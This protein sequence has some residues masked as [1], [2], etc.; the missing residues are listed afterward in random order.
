MD[1]RDKKVL[2]VGLARTGE[3]TAGFLLRRGARV[4]IT[5]KK[6]REALGPKAETWIRQ[7]VT[8]E[9]GGH[10]LASFL[11]SDLIVPSPGVPRVPEFAA[12]LERGIPV[13]SEI[14]LASRYLKGTIVGI[15]GT[16]GKSTTTTLLHRIL[17]DAGRP[18][19]LAGNIGTPLI[20]FVDR[21]R[22]DHFYVTEISSFQLEYIPTFRAALAL[23]LNIS[24]N[25]LDWHGTLDEYAAAKAKLLLGQRPGDR[26]VLNREDARIWSWKDKA[27]SD[28]FGFS[29]RRPVRRGAFIQDEWIV[30]RND[31]IVRDNKVVMHNKVVYDEKLVR[32][33]RDQRILPVSEIKLPGLHNREN[34]LAAALAARLLGI[35]ASRIRASVRGFRGL[36]HRLEPVLTVRGVSFV[37]DSKATTVDATL[38]ALA[39]F[40][41]PLILILGGKD[42]GADFQP[43]RRAVKHGVKSVVLVGSAAEKIRTVLQGAVPLIEARTYAEVVRKS[44]AAASRGDIVLLAPACTSWDM[45][46]DFEERGRVFKR[47]AKRLAAELKR[48]RG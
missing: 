40:D 48:G 7:G 36:E 5:E 41:R 17:K 35:P 42:K 2:V 47:E 3:A 25:H 20:S 9:T 6:P 34:V 21:S 31:R 32:D 16:N 12:A 30:V 24:G 18:A 38:K 1:L 22:D 14:E 28:V 19:F 26:S 13:W 8:L 23:I 44:F 46:A 29:G 27:A 4:T 10:T 15:T 39:S 33:D 43:L 45:F 37:N 11:N